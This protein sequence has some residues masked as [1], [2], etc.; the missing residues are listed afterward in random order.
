MKINIRVKLKAKVER[1]QRVDEEH[2]EAFIK[3]PPIEDRANRRLICLLAD[4]FGVSS[5]RVRI[6][7]GNKS[8]NKTV[9]IV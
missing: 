6:I 4:Y 1:L 5:S 7:A 9:E 3:E 8:R 2:F